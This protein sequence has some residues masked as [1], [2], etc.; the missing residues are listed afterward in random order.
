MSKNSTEKYFALEKKN[1]ALVT[2]IIQAYENMAI[3]STHTLQPPVIKC[4]ISPDFVPE[5]EKIMANLGE[6]I[7]LEEIT[8]SIGLNVPLVGD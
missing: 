4:L 7:H 6:Q 2:F 8:P 1:I 5:F 3:V